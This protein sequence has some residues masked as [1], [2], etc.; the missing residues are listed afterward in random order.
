M[1]VSTTYE[2]FTTKICSG[3]LTGA[4]PY[5]GGPDSLSGPRCQTPK[6]PPITGRCQSAPYVAEPGWRMAV[7]V[8]DSSGDIVYHAMTLVVSMVL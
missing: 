3:R 4:V 1:Y 6:L 7:T 2:C 5:F 8:G